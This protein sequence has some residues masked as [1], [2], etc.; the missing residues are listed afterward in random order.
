VNETKGNSK[1]TLKNCGGRR[2]E[3]SICCRRI[4]ETTTEK[5][6]HTCAFE[7]S[8]KPFLKVIIIYCFYITKSN[9]TFLFIL[10]SFFSRHSMSCKVTQKRD[11]YSRPFIVSVAIDEQISAP[12]CDETFAQEE[13]NEKKKKIRQRLVNIHWLPSIFH[14]TFR[15]FISS[16][17][18]HCLTE[19]DDK[20]FRKSQRK[21]KTKN[22]TELHKSH[23]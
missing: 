16:K 23:I 3:R 19:V 15:S 17:N 14:S 20:I 6:A 5:I 22:T 18:F 10:C 11:V 4:R 2:R 13:K 12:F 8:R 1:I 7:R 9:S 21:K